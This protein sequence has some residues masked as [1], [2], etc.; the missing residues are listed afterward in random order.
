MVTV[1]E[2]VRQWLSVSDTVGRT[3]AQFLF[4]MDDVEIDDISDLWLLRRRFLCLSSLDVGDNKPDGTEKQEEW[5]EAINHQERRRRG[6]IGTKR[7]Q[8]IKQHPNII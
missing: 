4:A 7:L 3:P 8:K 6:D 2:T 1:S 5:R